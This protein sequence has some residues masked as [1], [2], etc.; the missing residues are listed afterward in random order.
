MAETM[1]ERVARSMCDRQ[2]GDKRISDLAWA[3]YR[4][5]YIDDARAA[6]EAMRVPTPEMRAAVKNLAGAQIAAFAVA[7][8]PDM[9][10]AALK[11]SA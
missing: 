8:W 10:D 6:I 3:G 11:E 9:I 7:A 1:I 4:K 2:N 5:D